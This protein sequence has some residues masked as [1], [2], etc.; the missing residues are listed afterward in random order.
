MKTTLITLLLV[1]AVSAPAGDLA[2]LYE[3]AY[4]LETAR[5]DPEAA[6]AIYRKIAATEVTDD[7]RM[8]VINTLDRMRQIYTGHPE[9]N[10]QTQLAALNLGFEAGT[11]APKNPYP[12]AWGGGG[13]GYEITVDTTEK[14]EGLASCR[15]RQTGQGAFGTITGTLDPKLLAGK[16]VRYSGYLKLDRVSGMAG[17][18]MRADQN[19]K[20]AAFYNMADEQ[21]KGTTGWQ[22]YSFELSIPR[23]TDN[24]NFGALLGGSGTLWVDDITIEIID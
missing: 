5:G 23:E 11:M 14:K 16:N 6:L 15:I 12:A 22:R 18:W 9:A 2:Q 24:I 17:L 1:A 19:Q 10:L 21:L 13:N 3:K 20:P 8:V 4:F 7:N